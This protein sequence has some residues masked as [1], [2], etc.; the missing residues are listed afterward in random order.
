MKRKLAFSALAAVVLLGLLLAAVWRRDGREFAEVTGTVTLNGKPLDEVEI[1]FMPDP[2]KRNPGPHSV[3]YTDANG[4]Y[5]VHCE[6]PPEEGALLGPCRVCIRDITALPDLAS[7]PGAAASIPGMALETAPTTPR[8]KRPKVS[9]VPM[10][11]TMPDKTPLHDI[12]VHHGAQVLDFDI[13]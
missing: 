11:Y 9:R 3:A 10:V 8:D 7:L 1:V 12:E 13:K 5:R 4:H 6:R 2:A